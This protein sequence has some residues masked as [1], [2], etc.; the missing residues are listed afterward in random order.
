MCNPGPERAGQ[1]WSGDAVQEAPRR[2]AARPGAHAALEP[3]SK[4][5]AGRSRAGA[6]EKIFKFQSLSR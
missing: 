6:I 4:L 3:V 2:E 1:G 5:G